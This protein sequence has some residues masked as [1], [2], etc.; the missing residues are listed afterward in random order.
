[1]GQVQTREELV[2]PED[3]AQRLG[4]TEEEEGAWKRRVEASIVNGLGK[5]TVA[6]S[7]W[8]QLAAALETQQAKI[9][10]ELNEAR[11]SDPQNRGLG[12]PGLCELLLIRVTGGSG[13]EIPE[14]GWGSLFT[15]SY[16]TVYMNY[17]GQQ[18]G[19]KTV[20][21]GHG[22]YNSHGLR[23]PSRESLGVKEKLDQLVAAATE[24]GDCY[25]LVL[26]EQFKFHHRNPPEGPSRWD[27][28]LV[29]LRIRTEQQLPI[30]VL[31]VARQ[32]D[33][34]LCRSL[35]GETRCS[36]SWTSVLSQD[37]TTFALNVAADLRHP[38]AR[39]RLVFPN[40]TVYPDGSHNMSK[41]RWEEVLGA[42]PA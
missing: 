4:A 19:M 33:E 14:P 3:P 29:L 36:F 35:A 38:A 34:V 11:A 16:A 40:G 32:G 22:A 18:T 15:T 5:F 6:T 25:L 21:V 39:L 24:A 13:A 2:I 41:W 12:G 7:S 17:S 28:E 20:N 42:G 23:K 8:E 27:S 37:P 1:M 10:A 26:D 30:K 31:Q 9:V